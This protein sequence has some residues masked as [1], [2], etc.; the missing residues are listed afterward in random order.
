MANKNC[1][2]N[3]IQIENN[4]GI[5]NFHTRGAAYGKLLQNNTT[6]S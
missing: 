1:D 5:E 6:G 4:F 2:P 3:Q